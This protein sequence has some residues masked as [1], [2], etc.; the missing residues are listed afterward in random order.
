VDAQRLEMIQRPPA[1]PLAQRAELGAEAIVPQ[2]LNA[3]ASGL[4]V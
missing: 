4:P 2:G 3:L 1:P